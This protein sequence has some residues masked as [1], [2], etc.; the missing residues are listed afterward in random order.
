MEQLQQNQ[1]QKELK[2][3]TLRQLAEELIS[4]GQFDY[5]SSMPTSTLLDALNVHPLHESEASGMSYKELNDRWK[6]DALEELTASNIL[7]VMLLDKGKHLEKNNGHY[8]V[9]LP[10]ENVLIADRFQKSAQRKIAKSRKLLLR[11]PK[12]F[13]GETNEISSKLLLMEK[14]TQKNDIH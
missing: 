14:A 7:R 9:C 11:T 12:E 13:L 10:S 1:I 8:R 2:P 4:A 5:G 3:K 6:S